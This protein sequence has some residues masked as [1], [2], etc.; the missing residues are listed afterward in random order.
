M[1]AGAGVNVGV[2]VRVCTTVLVTVEPGAGADGVDGVEEV[3]A[4][5]VNGEPATRFVLARAQGKDEFR[6]EV[7]AFRRGPRVVF[8][9]VTYAASDAPARDAGRASVGSVTWAK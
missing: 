6:R 8:F 3:Q 2:A 1:L 5:S 7:T 4:T 9:L